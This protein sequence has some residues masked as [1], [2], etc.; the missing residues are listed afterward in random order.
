MSKQ[1]GYKKKVEFMGVER[2]IELRGRKP[3]HYS[4]RRPT[5]DREA[6]RPW[7]WDFADVVAQWLERRN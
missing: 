1:N 3:I 4:P 2:S 6:S 7:V 5:V